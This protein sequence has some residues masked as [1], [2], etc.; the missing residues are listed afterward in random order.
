MIHQFEISCK[1][2][3]ARGFYDP[4][5]NGVIKIYFEKGSRSIMDR[6]IIGCSKCGGTQESA[7]CWPLAQIYSKMKSYTR[8]KIIQAEPMDEC[9]F[10]R[11]V[12]GQNVENCET[13]PGYKMVDP[14]GYTSWLSQGD[15]EIT[16][17]EITDSEKE[18]I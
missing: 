17:R 12:K 5:N 9:S 13:Q 14:D 16:Y 3:G 10:L 4:E 18:L 1:K 6:V 2:C 15:F 11:E 7:I 8:S